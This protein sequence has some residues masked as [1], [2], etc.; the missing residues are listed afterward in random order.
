MLLQQFIFVDL[1]LDLNILT[2]KIN[3]QFRKEKSGTKLFKNCGPQD[4]SENNYTLL[5]IKMDPW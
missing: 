4:Y 5:T 3:F 1:I 2:Y